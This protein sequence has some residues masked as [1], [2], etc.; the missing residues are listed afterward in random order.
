MRKSAKCVC[1]WV[2]NTAYVSHWS[3][4]HSYQSTIQSKNTI[5]SL[6]YRTLQQKTRA[7]LVLALDFIDMQKRMHY[8]GT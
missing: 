7:I 4:H 3:Y 2:R 8:Q 1:K 5:V 6:S